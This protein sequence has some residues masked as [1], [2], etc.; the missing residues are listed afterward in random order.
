M[1]GF[2][3]IEI[4]IYVCMY[5]VNVVII[6]H[7]DSFGRFTENIEYQGVKINAVSFL[8]MPKYTVIGINR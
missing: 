4:Y 6:M 2:I 5:I 7:R 3:V 8:Q 1:Y